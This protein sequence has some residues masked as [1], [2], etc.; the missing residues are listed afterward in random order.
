MGGAFLGSVPENSTSQLDFKGSVMVAV[1]SSKEEVVERL[2]QDIYSKEEVWDWD[3]VQIY[4]VSFPL[5]SLFSVF[6]VVV[7]DGIGAL[8]DEGPIRG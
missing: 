6:V 1:A 5:V 3:K 2:K 4:P 8:G 7:E